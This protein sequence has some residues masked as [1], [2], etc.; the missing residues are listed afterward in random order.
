MICD[1]TESCSLQAQNRVPVVTVRASPGC[2]FTQSY[3]VTGCSF[4]QSE[5][6]V[7]LSI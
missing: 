6:A 1:V 2:S 7:A 5:S 4:T 3:G